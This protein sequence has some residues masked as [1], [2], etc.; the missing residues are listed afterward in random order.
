MEKRRERDT[1]LSL[2][3]KPTAAAV[4]VVP[5]N[6]TRVNNRVAC[7]TSVSM[8]ERLLATMMRSSSQ[9]PGIS[10][11]SILGGGMDAEQLVNLLAS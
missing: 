4:A 7:F 1:S 6:F 3:L 8:A 11:S 5:F 9:R 10:R 2:S